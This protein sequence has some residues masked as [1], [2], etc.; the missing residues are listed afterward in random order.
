MYNYFA[1]VGRLGA[2]NK[3]SIVLNVDKPY[4]NEQGIFETE[5]FEVLLDDKLMSIVNIEEG[6]LINIKGRIGKDKN[7][8][9]ILIGERM[10]VERGIIYE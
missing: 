6:N 2:I 9:N 1:L 5:T 10:I 3:N 8:N 4:R 7:N